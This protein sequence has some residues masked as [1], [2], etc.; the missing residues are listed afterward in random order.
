METARVFSVAAVCSLCLG[1]PLCAQELIK[2]QCFQEAN[3]GHVT[4]TYDRYTGEVRFNSYNS[5]QDPLSSIV[6]ELDSAATEWRFSVGEPTLKPNGQP[7]VTYYDGC[8]FDQEYFNV[9]SPTKVAIIDVNGMAAWP[10]SGTF[11]NV[12]QP[13]LDFDFLQ[14]IWLLSGSHR[15]GSLMKWNL[16]STTGFTG[17]CLFVV[18]EPSALVLLGLGFLGLISQRRRL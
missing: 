16:E 11:G 10:N 12:A 13:G 4:V 1:P 8:A 9:C 18:P 5:A 15:A 17:P 14:S 2:N 3:L 7:D 6:L